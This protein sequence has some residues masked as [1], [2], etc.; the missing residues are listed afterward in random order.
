MSFLHSSAR[1][2]FH[3]WFVRLVDSADGR[4]WQEFNESFNDI[5]NR[6]EFSVKSLDEWFDLFNKKNEKKNLFP[7]FLRSEYKVENWKGEQWLDSGSR[8]EV[9]KKRL[10]TVWRKKWFSKSPMNRLR[11]K[12]RDENR[13]CFSCRWFMEKPVD[14]NDVNRRKRF[15]L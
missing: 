15:T 10:Q 1:Y 12:I 3:L 11:V 6:K 5:L 7:R 9:W 8:L 13:K 4:E 14:R 2:L